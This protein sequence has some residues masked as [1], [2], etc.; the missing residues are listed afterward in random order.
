MRNKK[1][2]LTT[3][4]AVALAATLLIGGGTFAYLQSS[5]EDKANVFS[6]NR[7][8]VE[9]SETTGENYDI[10]P[11]TSQNKDPKVKVDNTVDAYVYVEVTDTTQGIVT[12]EMA[13]GWELLSGMD[14]V[15]YRE[16]AADSDVKEFS[17]LKG[18]KVTYSAALENSDMLDGEGNL[19]TG[20]ELTFKAFAIQKEGF[21]EPTKAYSYINADIVTTETALKEALQSES[22][23]V[24]SDDIEIPSDN[25]IYEEYNLADNAILDL[26]GYTMKVPYL[27]GIFQGK[28]VSIRNGSIISEADYPLFVGNGTVETKATIENIYLDGGINVFDGEAILRNVHA[29]ASS[30][31]YYAVWADNG[32]VITIESGTYIGGAGKPAVSSSNPANPEEDGP[33]GI[34]IIKGGRFNTD[35]SKYVADGYHVIQEIEDG[36]TWYAVV[37]D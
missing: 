6:T 33:A 17:V 30:K 35:I 26:N 1:K 5:T 21:E 25:D 27:K 2:T 20:M 32:A 14:N 11:G 29:D 28:N 22:S 18:D 12:Y 31:T 13:E 10:I 24:L 36:S 7:V 3:G 19:K 9:L 15:Y 16:V 23:V 8:T 34:V 37:A 4:L